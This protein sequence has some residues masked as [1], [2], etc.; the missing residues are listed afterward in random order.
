MYLPTQDT[1]AVVAENV[2]KMSRDDLRVA[3]ANAALREAFRRQSPALDEAVRDAAAAALRAHADH[4]TRSEQFLDAVD[5]LNARMAFIAGVRNGTHTQTKEQGTRDPALGA[6]AIALL[7]SEVREKMLYALGGFVV[8]TR[9]MKEDP[10]LFEAMTK[11]PALVDALLKRRGEVTIDAPAA[12]DAARV[13][14][15]AARLQT[16]A[17]G[18]K[19]KVRVGDDV[20]DLTD[21]RP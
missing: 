12:S 8:V 15:A 3:V 1:F 5:T 21:S 11:N 10:D 7:S 17:H 19:V 9:L 16:H 14:A 2:A 20:I 4:G 6:V 13:L 18:V